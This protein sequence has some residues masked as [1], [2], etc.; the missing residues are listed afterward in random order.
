MNRA[1]TLIQMI[2]NEHRSDAVLLAI[3]MLDTNEVSVV[4]LYQN[5]LAKAL[6][7][8]DCQEGDKECIW[9]EHVETAI[10]RTIIENSYPF[11]VKQLQTIR[12]KGKRVIVL[13]PEE[14]YHEIGAKMAHDFFLLHGYDAVF[15]GA[16]TPKEVAIDAVTFLQ[17]DYIAI[18]VTNMYNLV[19]AKRI[20]EEVKRI[21]PN[22]TILTGGV[23]F[24]SVT[25]L[26]SVQSDYHLTNFE[27]IGRL[28][29]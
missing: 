1:D 19:N 28:N 13:C 2:H 25:A 10:V 6:Q 14:E 22:V 21:A 27:S 18:S 20:V 4:E 7:E 16:N 26:E 12:P 17:P 15:I 9:K 5:I 23:A 29:D 8:I 3:D 24:T 11:I